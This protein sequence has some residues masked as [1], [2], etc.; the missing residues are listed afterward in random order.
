[1]VDG[2]SLLLFFFW[3]PCPA[4]LDGITTIYVGNL[5]GTVDEYLLLCAFA[6]FGPITH[7]QVGSD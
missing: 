2:C 3:V 5:P 1:M 4:D 6:P 7:V